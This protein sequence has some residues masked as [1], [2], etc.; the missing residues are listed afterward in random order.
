MNGLKLKF[1]DLIP[2]NNKKFV[3]DGI[4]ICCD[5][6][7]AETTILTFGMYCRM[8]RSFRHFKNKLETP[9]HLTGTVLDLD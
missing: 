4:K 9:Y 6:G 5:C 7:N 3:I 8:C 2:E 1:Q